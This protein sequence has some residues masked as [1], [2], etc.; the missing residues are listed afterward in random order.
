MWTAPYDVDRAVKIIESLCSALV[1]E[2]LAN[3]P[4]FFCRMEA[5]YNFDVAPPDVYRQM[6]LKLMDSINEDVAAT[7]KR[8]VDKLIMPIRTTRF[9]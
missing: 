6:A 1:R 3:M 9:S 7:A 2:F 5:S 8:V 4:P